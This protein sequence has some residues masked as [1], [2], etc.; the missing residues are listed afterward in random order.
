MVMREKEL[1]RKR[2][3]KQRGDGVDMESVRQAER[4]REKERER[5]KNIGIRQ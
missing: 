5:R 3:L 2:T 1:H 4:E